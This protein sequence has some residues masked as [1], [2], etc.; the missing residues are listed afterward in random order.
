MVDLPPL[1][2]VIA[3]H[4][5]SASKALGQNFLFDEQLLERI[6]AIPGHLA[7]RQVLEVGPGPGGL[8]RALL[9]AGA[10]VTAIEMDKR[11]LPALA[12]LGE[13][14]PG[15]LRVVEGDALKLDHAGLMAGEPFAVLS[16]LPY[17]VGTAL[18]VRWLGGETWPPL[19]TSLTLMFQQE[20]AQRIVAQPGTSA[21]GRLAVLAQWRAQAKLAM[22]VHRSAFTPPPKV[23]SAIVHVEPGAMPAGVSARML[24]RLTEAAFGQRRKMLRQSL[25]GVPGAVDALEVVGIDP[26]RRAETVTVT[27]FT[28]LARVLTQPSS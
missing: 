24:E 14:F 13:A 23:M 20:V 8:T 27:E 26:Q 11:C 5:L 17:N 22:K 25:K 15:Q 3:R 16:N 28:N 21:Y 2:E 9:R 1:R 12:E 18:F 10:R 19:W 6:A 7:G 4:G